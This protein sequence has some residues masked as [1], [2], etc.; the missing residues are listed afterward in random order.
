MTDLAYEQA[1]RA[2]VAL[3][4]VIAG[5]RAWASRQPK[6]RRLWL[7][8]S[9]VCGNH[10]DDSD[11]D[12]AV[13]ID[14]LMTEAEKTVFWTD[15]RPRWEAELAATQP[16]TP[17]LEMYGTDQIVAFVEECSVLVFERG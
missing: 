3:A 6:I 10:R 5:P 13:E 17:D 9:R 15:T 8:G 1:A 12:I 11:L 2:V 16:F 4:H 7:F 14:P